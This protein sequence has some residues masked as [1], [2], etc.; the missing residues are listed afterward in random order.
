MDS[1]MT[2]TTNK[3]IRAKTQTIWQGPQPTAPE[4]GIDTPLPYLNDSWTIAARLLDKGRN[5]Y[6][7]GTGMRGRPNQA[8]GYPGAWLPTSLGRRAPLI[9]PWDERDIR[10]V[11]KMIAYL[12]AAEPGLV[13]EYEGNLFED[14]RIL[15]NGDF[16][17]HEY[18]HDPS[19]AVSPYVNHVTM[20]ASGAADMPWLFGVTEM[21]RRRI[22]SNISKLVQRTLDI[23]DPERS[24][25]LNVGVGPDWPSRGFWGAHL[26]EPNHYPANYD[27]HNK[28][29]IA[30]MALAVFVRR[31]LDAAQEVDAPETKSLQTAFDLLTRAIEG[32]AWNDLAQYYYLQRDENSD[33]WFMSMNGLCEESRET[34]VVPHYAAELCA[35]PERIQAV[36]RV[37]HCAILNKRVFPM[38]PRYPT[39]SWYSPAHPNGVDMGAEVGQLGAAWDTPY[40]HCVQVLERL[41]LQQAVQ[42]AVLR[43]AEVIHRDQ[44]CL[45]SYRLDGT[46]DHTRFYNRDQYILSATAHLASIIE[47]LFGI[48]PAKTGFAEVNLRPNLP[49]YRRHRHTEHASDWAGRDNRIRVRLGRRGTM[50][51]VIRYDEAAEI[52]TL[53]TSAIAIPAHIRLPLDL[54]SRFKRAFWG[55]QP[56]TGSIEHG[57]DSDF[58]HVEHRLDGETLRIELNSH[59]QKGHGT[60]PQIH[61]E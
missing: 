61:P 41:G 48:T 13:E 14:A 43:R 22:F 47:G 57:M 8:G 44:D 24:G 34:D 26:G 59:P 30:G 1:N 18:Y 20:Y 27:G 21:A 17:C 15:K 52:L 32:P 45:E 16:C 6:R 7:Q 10:H 60:T 55:D 39:H 58:L 28:L 11:A 29:V 42:R 38:P 19:R 12:W 3:T 40:F 4:L 35:I 2:V 53:R 56:I 51:L 54:G 9:W 31:F 33:R 5:L 23:F 49:L 46:V 50:D 37:I 25:L 36:G